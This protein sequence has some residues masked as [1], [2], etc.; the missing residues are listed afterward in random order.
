[1]SSIFTLLCKPT[2][3]VLG[4]FSGFKDR[5]T[6][7]QIPVGF[8]QTFIDIYQNYFRFYENKLFAEMQLSLKI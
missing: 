5:Q 3:R 8:A 1:M 2:P 6:R 7:A 4:I